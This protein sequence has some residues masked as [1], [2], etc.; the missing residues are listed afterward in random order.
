MVHPLILK[1]G[2]RDKLSDAEQQILETSAFGVRTFPAGEEIVSEGN[3]CHFSCLILEGWASRN[4]QLQDGRQ[5]ITAFHIVGDFVDLHSFLLK[6]MDHTVAA[7]TTCKMAMVRHSALREIT[8]AHPHLTRMLWLSTLIDAAIHRE[9][10]VTLGR[11]PAPA[12]LAHLICELYL[13]LEAV[14]AAQDHRFDFP[15]TQILLADALGLSKVHVNRVVQELRREK[16]IS[17]RGAKVTIPDFDRLKRFA[18]FDPTY[19]NLLIEPR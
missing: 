14:G 10:L 12:H 17:W 11:L 3:A 9:W 8:E 18:E 6:P 7:V 15:V 16:L 5:Q 13:R 4:K 2:R 1:L 19:L